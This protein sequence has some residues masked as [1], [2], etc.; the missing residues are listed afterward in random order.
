MRTLLLALSFLFILS[1]SSGEDPIIEIE[2]PEEEMMEEEMN[3]E[4]MNSADPSSAV[5]MEEDGLTFPFVGYFHTQ[6]FLQDATGLEL[7][8]EERTIIGLAARTVG[9]LL[10][11]DFGN[12]NIEVYKGGIDSHTRSYIC[13][14]LPDSLK[15]SG[16]KV[17]IR[18]IFRDHTGIKPTI[19]HALNAQ[20]DTVQT[21]GVGGRT[22]DIVKLLEI[23]R[24]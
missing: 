11:D 24:E 5:C 7:C 16:L 8:S 2:D 12:W 17:K 21:I 18:G 23:E 22:Y 15:E 14:G 4:E 3:E 19:D 1:C 13:C 6:N 9:I 10:K 20:G